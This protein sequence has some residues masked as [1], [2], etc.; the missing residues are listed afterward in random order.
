MPLSPRKQERDP[1]IA[2]IR[3]KRALA[4]LI[5]G[6]ERLWVLVLPLLVIVA[7][8]LSLA[9]FGY[10]RMVPDWARLTTLGLLAVG[11]IGSLALVSRFRMPRDSEVDRHLETHNHIAHQALSAQ[12]DELVSDQP[13]ARALWEEHRRRM[14][15]TIDRLGVGLPR[16]DTPRRDPLALRAIPVL[17]LFVALAYSQSNQAGRI[18]DAFVSH[19]VSNAPAVRI[20]AWVAPPAYTKRAPLFLTASNAPTASR[21]DIPA[22]SDVV[23]RVTG[24][25]G[26]EQ[27]RFT[28]DGETAARVIEQGDAPTAEAAVS[29]LPPPSGG[30]RVYSFKAQDSGALDVEASREEPRSWSFRVIADEPP[31]IEFA[32]DLRRAVNGALEVAFLTED[33]Y[34]VESAIALIEPVDA[35]S[36]EVRPLYEQPDYR[37]PLQRR[38]ARVSE[39]RASHDLTE[40]PWAGSRVK[41]TLV[42]TDASGQEGRSE[43]REVT[44]PA[45]SFSEPLARAFVEHRQIMALDAN[46]VPRV[47]ALNDALAT[48]PEETFEDL[49]HF[50]LLKSARSRIVQSY[51]DDMLREAADYLWEIALGI[52]DGDLS[53]AERRLRDAQRNLAEALENGATDEEIQ[54]LM[55]ELRE[56]MQEYMQALAEE[57]QNS[58]QAMQ[59]P[60]GAMENLLRQQDI[61]SMLDQIEN[62]ARQGAR[63]EAQQML[64]ELQRMMNNL[65]AGRQQQQPN[66][67]MRQQMDELGELMQR[68]QQL[69]NETFQLDQALRERMQ[70]GLPE[71]FDQPPGQQQPQQGQQGQ[72][73]QGEGLEGMTREELQEA[74]RQLQEQQ[75]ALQEQLGELTE[76]LEGM[77]I[78]PGEGFG[79]AGEAMGDAAGSLGE[80]RGDRAVGQQGEAL[81]A[82]RQGAQQMVNQMMQA[83]GEGQGEGQG[84]SSQMRPGGTDPL[85]RPRSNDGPDFGDS[86]R[87][88][89]EI[90]I[91][92]AREILE[93]IRER[94]G[95]ALSPDMERQY[96]E[97]LLE[98]R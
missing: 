57:M 17:L 60:E 71:L 39:G 59:M 19:A 46:Q 7:L 95:N 15:A 88:P 74:L 97:R 10:F 3:Q 81:E 9:W 31:T 28:R 79:E 34:G 67:A 13:F 23:V 1:L 32:Q 80:G 86:V 65:Q 45:R 6:A 92:R 73:Q 2:R 43:T 75:Q 11:A 5:I 91:Q 40:H 8:F 26:D 37:L 66:N 36:S 29:D 64:S 33:D 96:L 84:T 16:P 94:L 98:M 54:A 85:G 83:M 93:A 18:G 30:A 63:D 22:G 12:E 51:N 90:D 77:G 44:L 4:R 47:L 61:E 21:F 55:D 70:E 50:L 78:Q 25:A 53:L 87:V 89:D 20:D 72:S 69:M 41:L 68:Q 14:A 38:G 56:A 27:I 76:Q 82:L 42:A 35:Q 62:L 49:T 58:D 52:E 48:A 24:G